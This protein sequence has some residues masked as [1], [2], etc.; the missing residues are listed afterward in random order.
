MKKKLLVPIFALGL[1]AG[2]LALKPVATPVHAEDEITEVAPAK[3]L[4]TS[5]ESEESVSDKISNFKDTYL[6]PLLSGVSITA[7]LSMGLTIVGFILNRRFVHNRKDAEDAVLTKVLD[8]VGVFTKLLTEI[9]QTNTL[10]KDTKVAFEG[11]CKQLLSTLEVV[12][13]LPAKVDKVVKTQ[14]AIGQLLG[15]ITSLDQKFVSSGI[16]EECQGIVSDIKELVK[17]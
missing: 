16:A 11:S 5:E 6:V 15:K 3:E 9:N 14:V 12:K 10:S 4:T 1:L 7:V 8:L 17:K 2:G 13:T